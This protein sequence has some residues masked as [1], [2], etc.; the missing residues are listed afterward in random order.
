MAQ[1]VRQLLPD[2]ADIQWP[3]ATASTN[4][5]LL[6]QARDGLP[7]PRL[8]GTRQQT[9]G[10]GRA[11][12]PFQTGMDDALTFSCA[13]ET[14]LPLAALP[15]L[16]VLFGLA[17]CEALASR[18]PAGHQLKLKWPNDLQ[19]GDAKLAGLLMESAN[20]HGGR[21]ARVVMGMGLNLRGAQELSA[22]LG[23]AIADWSIAECPDSPARL[24][25]T[26]ALA[27]QAAL[28]HMEKNWQPDTGLADLPERYHVHD[29]L[30][31]QD[32]N[33]QDQG[34]ILMQ[35]VAAGVAP[36]GRLLI[37]T[38]QGQQRITVGDV[39]VRP[40]TAPVGTAP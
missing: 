28:R 20:A 9:L 12:R 22:N 1:A 25:A 4:T 31:G 23:R 27:W 18:L 15:T 30:A 2:W 29:A 10:R 26:V 40:D 39:S 14:T 16:S 7:L 17:A 11:N 33:V 19:W 3:D 6:A 35:G 24:C 38:P 5:D 37:Q 8:R 34:R 32:I 36:D 13:F 21:S